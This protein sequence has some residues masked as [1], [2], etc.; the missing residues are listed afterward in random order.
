M[1]NG[2]TSERRAKQAEMIKTWKPWQQATGPVSPE[3]RA[4]VARNAWQGGHRATLRMLVRMVNA[5]I[6]VARDALES[7]RN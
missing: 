3:G 2:W 7:A 4:R 5:E 6:K 1:A